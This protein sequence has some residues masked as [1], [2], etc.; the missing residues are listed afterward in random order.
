[1]VTENKTEEVTEEQASQKEAL[2]PKPPAHLAPQGIRTFTVCR[3]SDETGVSGDGIVI[4]GIELATGQAVV[5]WLWPRPRG[6]IAVFDSFSDFVKVHIAP[7]PKNGTI[8]TFEDGEQKFYGMSKP[9]E[10]NEE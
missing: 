6:S 4:E 9:Q 1:M 2:K 3:Q 7:H 10:D 5:H 8:I